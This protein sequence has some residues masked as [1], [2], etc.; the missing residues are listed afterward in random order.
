[1]W[2]TKIGLRAAP[3]R[4]R[5]SVLALLCSSP[6]AWMTRRRGSQV[7][8]P[9]RR[10][11]GRDALARTQPFNSVA[12]WR[13]RVQ[14][15]GRHA[16]RRLT[17]VA[18]SGRS[19]RPRH[20]GLPGLGDMPQS[21]QYIPSPRSGTLRDRRGRRLVASAAKWLLPAATDLV[22]CDE[23]MIARSIGAPRTAKRQC[24]SESTMPRSEPRPSLLQLR[25]AQALSNAF[26]LQPELGASRRPRCSSSGA[27]GTSCCRRRLRRA[28]SRNSLAR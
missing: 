12:Q 4:R 6:A 11:H 3:H 8:Q 9:C 19:A 21:S 16:A 14:P 27:A 15:Q 26:C 25:P 24:L 28:R 7:G 5:G 18:W 22:K 2:C 13:T 17:I 10:A 20:A 23:A 1:L